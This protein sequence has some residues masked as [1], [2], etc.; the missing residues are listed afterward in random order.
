M[1]V[2]FNS[3]IKVEFPPKVGIPSR[4]GNTEVHHYYNA[5]K[6]LWRTPSKS[7]AAARCNM[8]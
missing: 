8:G 3:P 7:D 2:A 4:L 5:V 6:A 1:K